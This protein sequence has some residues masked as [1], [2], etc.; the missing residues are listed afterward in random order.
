MRDKCMMV[1]IAVGAGKPAPH[2]QLCEDHK[3]IKI[4]AESIV[5][6]DESGNSVEAEVG[7][8]IVLE[9]VEGELVALNDDGSA[10]VELRAANGEPIEYVEAEETVEEEV[11]V[12]D[13]DAMEQQ[14]LQAAMAEDEEAG[15]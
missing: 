14:L 3:M 13:M 12:D 5:G 9:Q 11:P 15:R 8:T 6:V 7:D 1:V 10:H 2:G 4:S